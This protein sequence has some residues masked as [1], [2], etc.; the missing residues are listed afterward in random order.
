MSGKRIILPTTKV[1]KNSGLSYERCKDYDETLNNLATACYVLSKDKSLLG[2]FF[3]Y[4]VKPKEDSYQLYMK[5]M[6]T[7][8]YECNTCHHFINTYGNAVYIN[9]NGK[10][11]S[12]FWNPDAAVG[13]MIPVVKAL[14]EI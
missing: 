3:T 13:F 4:K 12:V 9:E 14:K 2:T 6:K 8:N 5:M 10:L 7:R 11:E 1:E